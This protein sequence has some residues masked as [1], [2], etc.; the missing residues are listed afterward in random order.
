MRLEQPMPDTNAISCGGR[1]IAASARYSACSTPKSPHP[2]HQI[3]FRSLL[4]S[5]GSIVCPA[6]G[7][8]VVIASPLWLASVPGV[9]LEGLRGP[10]E[11]F[12]D[13]ERHE[14][15]GAALG[16]GADAARQVEEHAQDP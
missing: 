7:S 3:G 15:V 1:P 6:G 10:L 14:R 2:G 11:L 16:E 4:N 5:L 13:L 9:A 8:V 12:G